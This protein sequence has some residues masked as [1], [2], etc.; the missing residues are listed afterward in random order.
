MRVIDIP[1]TLLEALKK[2][3]CSTGD[4]SHISH[5]NRYGEYESYHDIHY[6]VRDVLED[7]CLKIKESSDDCRNFRTIQDT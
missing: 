1:D 2:L 4:Q 5:V 6:E 3:C 7:M